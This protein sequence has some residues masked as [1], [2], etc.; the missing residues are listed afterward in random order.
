MS[1]V[2][3]K[4]IEEYSSGECCALVF[5]II[6][7]VILFSLFGVGCSRYYDTFTNIN[8]SKES[9]LQGRDYNSLYTSPD[10]K[11]FG[12]YLYTQPPG[13]TKAQMYGR[14]GQG[15]SGEFFP[16]QGRAVGTFMKNSALNNLS[17]PSA[18]EGKIGGQ[19][20]YTG[21]EFSS[22]WNGF[23]NFG[24]PFSLQVGPATKDNN[25]SNSYLIDGSNERVGNPG[26]KTELACAYWWPF[27]KKGKHQYCTQGSDAMVPCKSRTIDKCGGQGGR[28]FLE[29]KN[30]PQW[31]K[32]IH[33]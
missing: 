11:S 12:S 19:P 14:S 28:R 1:F 31:K 8:D 3:I 22:A 9:D 26:Q 7:I 5:F 2:V 10:L 30:R 16:I 18:Q 6:F 33:P 21:Q 27:V 24:A 25:Y 15:T 23:N 4:P 13:D 29:D 32:V 20:N 17:L